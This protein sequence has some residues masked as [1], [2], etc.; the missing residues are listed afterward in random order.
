MTRRTRRRSVFAVLAVAVVGAGWF[1]TLPTSAGPAQ[2]IGLAG[3]A[4]HPVGAIL[5]LATLNMDG[6]EGTDGRVDLTRTANCFRRADVVALQEVHGFGGD[7]PTDQAQDLSGLLKLPFVFAPAERRW[8]HP[9]FGNALLCGLPVVRWER[10]VLPSV[11]LH[12]KRNYLSATATWQGR[13]LNLIVTHVDFKAGGDEQLR[14]VFARFLS[15]PTP[16]VLMGDL[17]H[18]AKDVQVKELLATPGVEEAVSAKLEPVPGRVD[19]IFLRGLRTLDAGQVELH[20]SDHPAYW[21][22]V[23]E[24]NNR[25]PGTRR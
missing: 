23:T 20:A 1:V 4:T 18:P 11:P 21:A 13:P 5:R 7:P 12:A 22:D 15:L 3:A 17:N 24:V 9:S 14:E 10:V 8:G 6:G 16:A 2:G 19:W 25:L